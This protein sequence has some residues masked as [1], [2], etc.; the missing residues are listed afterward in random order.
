VTFAGHAYLGG[1]GR[2]TLRVGGAIGD[3]ATVGLSSQLSYSPVTRTVRCPAC[4]SNGVVHMEEDNGGSQP[5]GAILFLD[6]QGFNR[7]ERTEFDRIAIRRQLQRIAG[8][9][10]VDLGVSRDALE[11][12]SDTGDGL[13]CIL[14][15]ELDRRELLVRFFPSLN[16]LLLEHNEGE[17]PGRQIRVRT[18]FSQGVIFRD[19]PAL[20]GHGV[21]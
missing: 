13:L 19:R 21:V 7:P 6:I 10:L 9:L 3:P 15:P 20:T 11:Q 8:D 1:H 16:R 5:E 14:P 4:R 2:N 17:P 18:V 12:S